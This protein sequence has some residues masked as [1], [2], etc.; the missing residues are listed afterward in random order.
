MVFV[1]LN[2][3]IVLNM[4]SRYKSMFKGMDWGKCYYRE[5]PWAKVYVDCDSL[6]FKYMLDY[7]SS[8]LVVGSKLK[9]MNT[10]DTTMHYDVNQ[11]ATIH[12]TGEM[13][14]QPSVYAKR[15]THPKFHKL[16]LAPLHNIHRYPTLDAASQNSRPPSVDHPNA[17]KSHS[18]HAK[19]FI[20]DVAVFDWTAREKAMFSNAIGDGVMSHQSISSGAGG[21]RSSGGGGSCSGGSSC[22]KVFD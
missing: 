21:R 12:F 16:R 4:S 11:V 3:L 6:I 5:R 9:G 8:E 17:P 18:A 13:C 15:A 22:E 19:N 10:F 20:F 14:A 2:P 7:I 1:Y